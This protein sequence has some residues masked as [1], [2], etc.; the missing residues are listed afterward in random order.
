MAALRAGIPRVVAGLP[1]ARGGEAAEAIMTT[2]RRPKEA[3]LRLSIG[4]RD[5]GMAAVAKGSGMVAPNM[6]T[7][8]A[9]IVSDVKASPAALRRALKGVVEGTFNMLD[10][11]GDTSCNDM[12]VALANG[13]AGNRTVG[14]GGPDYR[15]L[16][17]ALAALCVRMVRSMASDGDGATKALEVRVTGAP[18]DASARAMAKAVV[19]SLRVKAAVH[20]GDPNWGRVLVAAGMEAPSGLKL[21]R[22]TVAMGRPG[23]VEVVAR[24]GRRTGDRG[25][26]RSLLKGPEVVIELRL[27][28]GKGTARAWGCDLSTQYVEINADYETHLRAAVGRGKT[29]SEVRDSGGP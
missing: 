8:L 5:V 22:S 23:R 29:P 24:G 2:D 6:G 25:R 12:V 17:E 9:F 27:H 18:T 28:Q 1:K 19:G 13:R 16:R 11:D 26:A 4:G 7:M 15:A 20:G 14:V 10:I 21:D 3:S